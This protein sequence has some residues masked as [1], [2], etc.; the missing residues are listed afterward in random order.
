MQ[1]FYLHKSRGGRQGVVV[2]FPRVPKRHRWSRCIKGMI[3]VG[4]SWVLGIEREIN[5]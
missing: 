2:P 3:A 4:I 1:K 5:C